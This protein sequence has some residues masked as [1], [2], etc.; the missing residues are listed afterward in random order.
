MEPST[1]QVT[2]ENL[3][4]HV[5]HGYADNNGVKIHYASLGSGPLVVM[6]HGFFE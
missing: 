3:E 4:L 5:Q 2:V 6:I 1:E